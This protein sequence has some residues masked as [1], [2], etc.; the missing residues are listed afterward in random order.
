MGVETWGIIKKRTSA[1]RIQKYLKEKYTEVTP[2]RSNKEELFKNIFNIGF[3]DKNDARYMYIVQHN[4]K[5]P[6]NPEDCWIESDEGN[7][8][9]YFDK[10]SY[11]VINL[12]YWGNSVKII[13]DIV[14]HFG[15]GFVCECD[16]HD[17][18]HK[19]EGKNVKRGK[20]K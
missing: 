13:K 16:T 6:G 11:T 19:V 17:V 4:A 3:Y 9:Y 5:F 14:K 12:N 1:K 10:P 15:G 7:S 8:T 18:Y 2:V 20:R